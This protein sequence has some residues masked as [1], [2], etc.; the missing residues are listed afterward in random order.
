MNQDRFLYF[1]YGSNMFTRRL[2]AGSRAPSVEVVATGYVAGHRLTLEKV[3]QEKSGRRSGKCNMV[4]TENAADRTYGVLFSVSRADEAALDRAEKGYRKDEFE[5]I[6]TEGSLRAIAYVA[7]ATEKDP[8]LRPY[9]WYKALVVAGATEHRLPDD[10]RAALRAVES[11]PD[12]MLNRKTKREAEAL[13][14]GTGFLD[15]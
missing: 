3:S 2:C 13:L 12:P 14:A 1:A 5:V 15:Q 4:A 11:Q 6:T 10:Y 9:H 7:E 8:L